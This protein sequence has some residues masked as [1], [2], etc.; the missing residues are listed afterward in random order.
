MDNEIQDTN[1]LRH[2]RYRKIKYKN[3]DRIRLKIMT[4]IEE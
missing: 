3:S 1:F 4:K 2:G